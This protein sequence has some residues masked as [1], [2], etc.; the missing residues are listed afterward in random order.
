[1]QIQITSGMAEKTY[2]QMGVYRQNSTEKMP[3]CFQFGLVRITKQMQVTDKSVILH[4]IGDIRFQPNMAPHKTQ[5]IASTGL[6]A[7]KD[8]FKAWDSLNP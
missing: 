5:G 3:I 2:L 4:R 1:M 6:H 8:N 7:A